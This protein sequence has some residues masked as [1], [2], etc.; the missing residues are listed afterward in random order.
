MTQT[1]LT[2]VELAQFTGTETWYRH[3]LN[4]SVLYTDGIKYLAERAGA[5]WLVDEIALGQTLP[6]LKAEGFQVWK[7]QVADNDSAVLICED[8]NDT[9]VYRK[10]IPFTDFP[11]PEIMIFYTDNVI[12]LPSEY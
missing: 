4:P 1:T 8:G 12:L 5:Y 11:L 10:D 9:E 7:L 2:K 6:T 3:A